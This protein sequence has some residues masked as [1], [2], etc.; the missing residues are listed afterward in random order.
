MWRRHLTGRSSMTSPGDWDRRIPTSCTTSRT[1]LHMR[2]FERGSPP[3]S[4][5]F[6][7]AHPPRSR[8]ARVQRSPRPI[9][10]PIRRRRPTR[11][12]IARR[13]GFAAITAVLVVV[14]ARYVWPSHGSG[15]VRGSHSPKPKISAVNQKSPIKHVV[16]I[17]KEN[18]TFNEFFGKYPGAAGSTTGGTL[19]CH[20]HHD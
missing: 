1:G 9:L 18:R 3:R 7:L 13:R 2:W 17:V 15:A 14:A 16:F 19:V 6:A 12:Q 20:T 5:N 4:R 10:T 11:R 8:L